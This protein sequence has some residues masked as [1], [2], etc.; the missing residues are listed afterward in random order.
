MAND[1]DRLLAPR[2]RLKVPSD[3]QVEQ[4]L[5]GT[6][7]FRT[8]DPA[9]I[10]LVAQKLVPRTYTN[11]QIVFHP[12]DPRDGLFVLASG[13]VKVTVTSPRGDQMVLATLESPETFGELSLIDGKP[14]SAS[15]EVVED[16]RILRLGREIWR[17]LVDQPEFSRA[18]L[19]SASRM[20]RRLTDQASDFAF[21]DLHGRVAKLLIRYADTRGQRSEE[22]ILLDL[23]LTQSDLAQ[24]VGGSR[25]SV[26]QILRS[27]ENRDYLEI[28]NK[29]ILLKDEERLRARAQL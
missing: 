9:A 28:R 5:V 6:D 3:P 16:A 21:L 17:P 11:G 2:L 14:R 10:R 8:F 22:G 23:H 25:Q 20:V 13:M 29:K 27:L 24:M 4:A 18:L 15:V 1:S 19:R 7:L 26:N 12:D